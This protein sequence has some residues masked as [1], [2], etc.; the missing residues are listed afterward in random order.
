MI[1]ET[2]L[3]LTNSIGPALGNHLWQ[4]TVF[5]AA[6]GLL[7]ALLRRNPAS[8]RYRLWVL[9]SLK[10]LFPFSLLIGLGR[11]FS[12]PRP[13]PIEPQL[14]IYSA[15]DFASRPF[16]TLPAVSSPTQHIRWID[17]F[18][19]LLPQVL[20]SVWILGVLIVLF[21]WYYRW[22]QL[23]AALRKAELAEEGREVE[24]LRR[25]ECEAKSGKRIAIIRSRQTME[26]GVFGIFRPVMLW[27]DRLTEQLED[28]HIEAI[29]AHELIHARR[30]DN[31]T[32]AIHMVVEALF[33]FH[34]IVWWLETRMLDERERACDEAAVQVVGRPDVYAE[35][36]LRACRFCLESPL[37]CISG[38]AG[39]NL[40]NRILR[41]LAGHVVQ[42]LDLRRKALLC[43][44]GLVSFGIPVVFG[45]VNTAESKTADDAEK[46]PAFEVISIRPHPPGYW[47]TFQYSRFTA[48]GYICKNCYVQALLIDAYDLRDPKLG[49]NLIP[50]APKWI[51]T[52]WY[53]VQAKMSEPEIEKMR[54]LSV[55]EQK[56]FGRQL[57]QSL[58]ADR[59]KLAV[60]PETTE[61]PAYELRLAKN[62][63]RNMKKAADGENEAVDWIDSGYGQYHGVSLAPLVKLLEM[64]TDC[65]VADKTG[66][67]GK[68]DFELQWARTPAKISPPGISAVPALP[69]DAATSRPSIFA[70]LREQL[71][72]ELKPVKAP[73]QSIVIEHIEKPSPN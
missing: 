7:T 55:K 20:T 46:L 10:F 68:Y 3:S 56:V 61:A 50:G 8:V 16:A 11:R 36:L 47:P 42:K 18:V 62:G 66:L 53:D 28:E 70:A 67:S 4:S 73:L 9:A 19:T 41:I 48:D 59:F 65:P 1:K 64:L 22:R 71:G 40:R 31:L 2:L 34:P 13:V 72:L 17:H 38:I 54:T 23:S 30:R 14:T 52:D 51:R 69:E 35:S 6:L 39:A 49:P 45:A 26:P 12:E 44:V 21:V 25:I 57:L 43:A 63:P 33:W 15:I 37:V 27:P 60:R 5:A 29:M 32:A 58:L 24:I